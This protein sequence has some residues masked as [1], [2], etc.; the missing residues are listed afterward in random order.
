MKSARSLISSFA[1]NR[2]GNMATMVAVSLVGVIGVAGLA[3][4]FSRGSGAKAGL[5]AAADAAALAG[6][7]LPGTPAER[8]TIARSVF[9]ANI[10]GI[11]GLKNVTM[12]PTNILKANS[13][14]GY[15]VHAK[16]DVPTT[17]GAILGVQQL[18]IDAFA[19]AIGTIRSHTEVALVL[20]TTYSMTGWK[21][22]TL[23][24]AATK[25]VDELA[26][27]AHDPDYLKMAIVPFS[28]YVNVGIPNRTR[29]WM[30]VRDDW[31]EL[32]PQAC[33]ERQNQTGTTNCRMVNFPGSSGSPGSSGTPAGTCYNDGV[34]YSCGGSGPTPATPPT[35]PYSAN[36][37]DPVYGTP[38]RVCP[39]PIR[40]E[41]KWHGCVG[42]RNYPLNV[43][44]SDYGTRIPGLMDMPCGAP[45]LPLTSSASAVKSAISGLTPNGETY[46]PEGLVWGWRML[47]PQA[48][49]EARV[50]NTENKTRKFLIL[51]TDG[52]NTKSPTYPEHNGSN[53]AQSNGFVK[54]AC[55][56]IKADA[57]NKITMF[58]VAFAVNDASTKAILKQCA[59]ATGG[60]FYDASD[61]AQFVAAFSTI[62]TIIAELR[63]SK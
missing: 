62:S 39:P 15:K 33:Y 22:A 23:K 50:N 21:I 10:A 4:D 16:G 6:A 3:I 55:A 61:A 25:M 42:S 2:A 38:T 63:L 28:Q 1:R 14:Y 53:G 43:K 34:P 11:S 29:P 60:Q 54:E 8:A 24:A 27:L 9:E 37:C 20:D 13:N 49:F 59:L 7:R 19:E 18:G 48:P 12:T 44:D 47:S 30:D 45:I 46:I 26:P 41:H 35:P 36:V 57:A 40:I 31:V 5:F 58:T 32:I 56:N 17:L 51:M 52:L